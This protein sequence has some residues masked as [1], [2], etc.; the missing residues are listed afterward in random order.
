MACAFVSWKWSERTFGRRQRVLVSIT[1]VSLYNVVIRNFS[2]RQRTSRTPPLGRLLRR[3]YILW[4]G[5]RAPLFSK[6]NTTTGFFFF[7]RSGVRSP[8]WLWIDLLHLLSTFFVN[9]DSIESS[10]IAS[11]MEATHYESK[12]IR[13]RTRLVMLPEPT[14]YSKS[15]TYLDV[16]CLRNETVAIVRGSLT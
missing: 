16:V 9:L 2:S 8:P 14:P 3:W 5:G 4:C 7:C 12:W 10:A 11:G 13:R 6:L 15:F 1:L